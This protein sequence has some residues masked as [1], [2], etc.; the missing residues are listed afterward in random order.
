MP[1]IA[2]FD[3]LKIEMYFDDHLPP[4]VHAKYAENEILVT[5]REAAVYAG[6][7]PRKQLKQVQQYVSDN[8][9]KLL[10]RWQQYNPN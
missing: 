7:L 2:L 8:Q 5:I 10:E 4:H 1:T 9:E 3:G 6:Y